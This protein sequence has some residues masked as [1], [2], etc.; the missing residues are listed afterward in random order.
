MFLSG[1]QTERVATEHLNIMNILPMTKPWRLTFS[2]GR[3]LQ[4]PALAGWGG[5]P[6]GFG[7]GQQALYHRARCNSAASLGKY[8]ASMETERGNAVQQAQAVGA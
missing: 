6:S 4:D 8:E 2:Y 7:L 3:A 5:K 1:G